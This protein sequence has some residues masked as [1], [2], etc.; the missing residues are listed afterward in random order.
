MRKQLFIVCA[1]LALAAAGCN[2]QGKPGSESGSDQG[3]GS[4]YET[5][6]ATGIS[7]N[8]TNQSQSAP[9]QGTTPPN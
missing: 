3:T 8:G 5:N 1:V 2:P 6:K 4:R 7:T 9:Q